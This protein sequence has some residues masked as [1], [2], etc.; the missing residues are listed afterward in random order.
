MVPASVPAVR[1]RS[2][3]PIYRHIYTKIKIALK[4]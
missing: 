1:P 4:V 3:R 2:P